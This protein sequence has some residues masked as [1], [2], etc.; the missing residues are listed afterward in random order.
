MRALAIAALFLG[1]TGFA[2]SQTTIQQVDF[3]NFSYP[4][5]GPLLGHDRLVWLDQS[6]KSHIRLRNGKDSTGFTLAS[7]AFAHV[8]GD[9][10]ED[11]IV[12]LHYDTGGTQQTDYIYIYSLNSGQPRL[13]AYCHTG[14][15]SDSGLHKVYGQDGKLVVELDDPDKAIALCCSTRFIR[16]QYEWRSGKFV[17]SGPRQFG[18]IELQEYSPSGQPINGTAP[19]P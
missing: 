13:L 6:A 17:A 12:V 4:R 14:D 8:T 18:A 1:S 9:A 19:S 7:V 10:K 5:T 16:T 3:K 15:R 11:A 2:L